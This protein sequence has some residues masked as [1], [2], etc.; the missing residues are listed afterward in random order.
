MSIRA[1]PAKEFLLSARWAKVEVRRLKMKVAELET[2]VEHITANYS[3]MPRG[4]SS[5][6]AAAWTALA[7]LRSEYLAQQVVAEQKEKAVSD[8]IDLLPSPE[9]REVLHLRYCLQLRWTEIASE[10]R[11]SGYYY[12]ERQVFRLHGKALNEAR[13]LWAEREGEQHGD[14]KTGDT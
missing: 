11:A 1:D 12:S 2:Q 14:N 3:G 4:G 9:S 10:L 6:V 13:R 5:E 7:A 8:F